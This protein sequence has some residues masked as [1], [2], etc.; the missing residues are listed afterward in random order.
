[1]SKFWVLTFLSFYSSPRTTVGA[2]GYTSTHPV[3]RRVDRVDLC[4]FIHGKGVCGT[5]WT[6]ER[7]CP[8]MCLDKGERRKICHPYKQSNHDFSVAWTRPSPAT[9][10]AVPV[11][12]LWVRSLILLHIGQ[13]IYFIIVLRDVMTCSLGG[14]GLYKCCRGTCCLNL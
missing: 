10:Y 13:R 8:I 3:W 1:M 5:H 11:Y 6:G 7:T 2:W 14:I 9:H 4:R 12:F